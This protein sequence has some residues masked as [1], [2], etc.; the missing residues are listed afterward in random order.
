MRHLTLPVCR[1]SV[2]N[3]LPTVVT[4]YDRLRENYDRTSNMHF[5]IQ[6]AVLRETCITN[7]RLSV[8]SVTVPTCES[9]ISCYHPSCHIAYDTSLANITTVQVTL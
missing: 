2:T 3:G 7:L 1:L 4:H 5:A 6:T 8:L 9:V